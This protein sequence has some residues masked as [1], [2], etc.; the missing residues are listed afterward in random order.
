[1]AP[2]NYKGEQRGRISFFF[3]LV[4]FLFFLHSKQMQRIFLIAFLLKFI[5]LANSSIMI[6]FYGDKDGVFSEKKKKKN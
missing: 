6:D 2:Y 5:F 3:H 4:E 1:M